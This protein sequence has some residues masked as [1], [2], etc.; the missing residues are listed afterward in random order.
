MNFVI[1]IIVVKT[2]FDSYVLK[3][4]QLNFP[5]TQF[6]F[7][8][9]LYCDSRDLFNHVYQKTDHETE[10]NLICL[11]TSSVSENSHGLSCHP[12]SLDTMDLALGLQCH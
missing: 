3:S 6:L 12:K 4:R 11:Y 1:I 8:Y 10:M 2:Y 5:A 9:L 7:N